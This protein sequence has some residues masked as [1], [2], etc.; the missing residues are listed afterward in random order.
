VRS[1][2]ARSSAHRRRT[3]RPAPSPTT[4]MGCLHDNR[5]F[6]RRPADAC[7][8][9]SPLGAR[10]TTSRHVR[11]TPCG[12]GGVRRLDVAHNSARAGNLRGFAI[13]SAFAHPIQYRVLDPAF[14]DTPGAGFWDA[15][16]RMLFGALDAGTCIRSAS[17]GVLRGS[18][19]GG[20]GSV[21][22]TTASASD[23]RRSCW[24]VVA[25]R[26]CSSRALW[27]AA[28]AGCGIGGR[29]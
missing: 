23:E 5:Q 6:A 18:R 8:E 14:G 10:R 22:R 9:L 1:A 4:P 27:C 19:V 17:A 12:H 3:T 15:Q 28:G 16:T 24:L 25:E 29:G 21:E 7:V 2:R 26:W 11:T 20:D 13:A